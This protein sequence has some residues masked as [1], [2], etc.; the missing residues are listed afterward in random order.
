MQ[1]SATIH[2]RSFE[3]PTLASGSARISP[4]GPTSVSSPKQQHSGS[5]RQSECWNAP[6]TFRSRMF[7]ASDCER[8]C[9]VRSDAAVYLGKDQGS[10][11]R[12]TFSLGPLRVPCV[13]SLLRAGFSSSSKS[14][15][16]RRTGAHHREAEKR[17]P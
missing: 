4:Q 2:A 15:E 16:G 9:L 12:S 5:A 14:P 1:R 8:E 3:E 7:L 13:Q 17:Q 10:L 6:K 11:S